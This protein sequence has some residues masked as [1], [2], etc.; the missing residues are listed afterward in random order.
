MSPADARFGSERIH[1]GEAPAGPTSWWS[2]YT[3]ELKASGMSEISQ[4]VIEADARHILDKGVFGAG[5]PGDSRWPEGRVRTGAVMG[6][7]QSGKTASLIAV[8][9]LA[10]DAGV[11]AIVVLGGTRTALWLQ[12]AHRIIEQLDVLPSRLTRR[13]FLPSPSSLGTGE[14]PEA[15][16][17]YRLTSQQAARALE[18]QRPIV[19]V[20][21]KNVAHLAELAITLHDVVYPAAAKL[22]RPFH[23][24][25]VDDEADD[26]SIVDDE[27]P[28][29]AQTRQVPRRIRDLWESR[30]A[31]GETAATYLYTTYLAYTAT[32]QANF[33]Q[34]LDNPL[35]PRDFLAS[36]RTPGPEGDWQERAATYR[37]PEGARAWY[38]GGSIFY[39][40]LA[41]VPLC[42]GFDPTDDPDERMIDAIRAFLVASAIRSARDPQKHGP[43]SA[44]TVSF[45]SAAE[46]TGRVLGP[47]SML[48]HP[49]SAKA[50]HF[51]SAARVLAWSKGADVAQGRLLHGTGMRHLAV[52]G[53][54]SDIEAHADKWQRWFDEYR[55]SA[56]VVARRL[57][58]V[59]SPAV[60][61]PEEWS[62]MVRNILE[63]VVPGTTVAVINSDENADD[64][65]H[66]TPVLNDDGTWS[67]ATNLSTIFV[68]GNVM[69]RGLTL[70]GLTTTFFSR[71]TDE[72][73]ADTQMQMQRWFG[74][75]GNYIDLCRV[76]LS[77]EQLE[78]FEHYHENDEALRRDVLSAMALEEDSRPA[79]AVLQGRRFRATGKV[80]NLRSQPLWPGPKPFVRH[81]NP[82][83]DD[84]LNQEMVAKLF[85]SRE[86]LLAPAQSGRQGVLL[87][88]PLSL[89]ETADLLDQ[90]TYINHR[91]GRTGAESERWASVENHAG[92]DG[93]DPVWPLYRPPADVSEGRDLGVSSPYWIA[94]YLR[95]W[96]A[97]LERR[98]PG[99]L[100]TDEPPV[101]WRLVDLEVKQQQQPRFSIGLRFG[102]GDALLQGP[103]TGL[104]VDSH[105]MK[106]KVK[107]DELDG[108]WGARGVGAGGIRGDEFF[109]MRVRGVDTSRM[110]DGPR[111]AGS[112]GLILFHLVQ[113]EDADASLALGVVL[114]LGG[115][116]NIQAN[117]TRKT[118]S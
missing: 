64:R 21:M 15:R 28:D 115:P 77:F 108:G 75:R 12:T 33:L 5:S 49:S 46:A 62:K 83:K 100:T 54:R 10:L 101:P 102:D 11:D 118:R 43:A 34:D 32:P 52:E 69:S 16:A 117:A 110:F 51:E 92:I 55:R 79:I 86:T 56:S 1:L 63:E 71:R 44:R 113:R 58:L 70:E 4:R 114:P 38:T 88:R 14:S 42:I 81:M 112:D 53:V 45:S 78:L 104:P 80:G 18:K 67:A 90:L 26:S 61:D 73:L 35:A 82:P 89:L 76:V 6:A 22:E 39:Q 94:A 87:A 20:A 109:D 17:A 50:Q 8:A 105:P 2:G 85:L 66:F 31:N 7:V 36:L 48:I 97:S 107:E 116:D 65:P 13:L 37:V 103:L 25:V 60:P 111:P 106:R 74:Y 72:P 40:T 68:A 99:M 96:A 24:L 41:D 84:R 95:L 3:R 19:A 27:G 59:P 9:A 29:P 98:I 47:T 30:R 57:E 23:L 93:S 91:P